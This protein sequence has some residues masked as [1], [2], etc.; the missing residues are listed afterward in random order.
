MREVIVL[1]TTDAT[2]L[3]QHVLRSLQQQLHD[4]FV[5]VLNSYVNSGHS[6]ARFDIRVRA[7]LHQQSHHLAPPLL[8]C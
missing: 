2:Y 3:P 6:L 8:H 1:Q 4:V 5:S 7:S